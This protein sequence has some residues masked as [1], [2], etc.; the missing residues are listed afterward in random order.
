[1]PLPSLFRNRNFLM[2]WL[3]TIIGNFTLAVAMLAETWYVVKTLGAKEQLGYVMIAASVPRILLMAVGG[4][5]ADRIKRSHILMMSMGVRVILLLAVVALLNFQMLGIVAITVFAFLY[6]ALD[7]F[8]WPAQGALVPSIVPEQELTRANS[9]MLTTNQIGL[10]FGPVLGSAMLVWFDYQ[11]VFAISAG[12]LLLG[13]LTML[14]MMEPPVTPQSKQSNLL[15]EL[16]EGIT[17]TLNTPELRAMMI[18]YAFANLL[19]MGPLSL[20]IPL[21]VTEHLD[22]LPETLGYLQ[23]AGAA[24]MVAGGLLLTMWPPRKKRLLMIALVITVEG[25]LLAL[26]GHTYWV[27]AAVGVQFLLG[28]GI[29]S[30]NVPMMSVIQQYTDREK[31]G[32]VM[33]LNTM[34][35]MGLS[36]LSYAMV[37]GLLA[38][39]VSIGWIMPVFGLVMSAAMLWCI[40]AMPVVRQSD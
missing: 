36:P 35:A 23:S 14:A 28:L 34:A 18:I 29:A 24:G 13:V 11:E 21:V 37:T 27:W 40:A 38:I 4:V 5:M 12:G 30:N 39:H 17:Y 7:A 9:I 32:R 1:M 22:G 19:F 33:S 16:R 20:G 15:V 10:V 25:V 3:A 26:Q 8:F 2:L 6:G 31:I